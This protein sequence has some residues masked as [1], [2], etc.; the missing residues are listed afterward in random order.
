MTPEQI[1]QVARAA[2][3]TDPDGLAVAVAIAMA[4]SG[5]NPNAHNARPP[6]NSYGLWQVNMIG[7]LG[8]AR[9]RQ[10]NLPVNEALYDP[11]VNAQAMMLISRQGRLWV[12]WTTYTRGAYIRHLPEARAGALAALG[13]PSST[14]SSST[15]SSS[16]S[17]ASVHPADLT[18]IPGQIGSLSSAVTKAGEWAGNRHNWTRVFYVLAG[19]VLLSAALVT[20]QVGRKVAGGA[21]KLGGAVASGGTS[22]EAGAAAK[23][24]SGAAKAGKAAGAAKAAAG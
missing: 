2:G 20:T 11:A 9:R 21:V 3:L 7:G 15:S 13:A 4:E 22:V 17:S 5:G 16:S 23:A 12:P 19:G 18:D 24:A 10:L 1:A 14:S 6:D 8:P